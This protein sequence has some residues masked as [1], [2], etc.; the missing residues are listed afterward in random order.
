ML[1]LATACI[2]VLLLSLP[3][4]AQEVGTCEPGLAERVLDAAGARARIHNTGN[5]FSNANLG[6]RGY[7][8]AVPK[9]S[10]NDANVAAHALWVAGLVD[11]DTL[12]AGSPWSP[13]EFWPGPIPESGVPTDCSEFD[14][15]W[16]VRR[17]DLIRY[18]ESGEITE[19]LGSW[20]V[21]L[22]APVIDGD[23]IP[24]NYDLG[25]GDQ[26]ALRGDQTVWWLMNDV[27]NVHQVTRSAPLGIEVRAEASAKASTVQDIH[28]ATFYRYT[29]T[30]RSTSTIDRAFVGFFS[31]MTGGY[32]YQN[33]FVGTDTTLSL[34]YTYDFRPDIYVG[35]SWAIGATVLEGPIILPDGRDNDRD[36]A[37]DEL[38]ERGDLHAT[39]LLYGGGGDPTHDEI[40]S[41]QDIYHYLSGSW[42]DGV[43]LTV[44]G[45]GYNGPDGGLGQS[46]EGSLTRYIFSGEPG[47]FWSEPCFQP[48]CEEP[49]N[50]GRR[51]GVYST[52]PF[53]LEPGESQ[54]VSI[55]IVHAEGDNYLD[56]VRA[57]KDVTRYV[58]TAFDLGLLDPEPVPLPADFL[59]KDLPDALGLG[60][61]FPNPT[62]TSVTLPYRVPA[63]LGGPI[64]IA[65]T[66]VLGREVAVVVDGTPTPGEY[67]AVLDT[68]AFAPGVYTVRMQRALALSE[69]QRFTVVR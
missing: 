44:G 5:L 15:L 56:A 51:H 19:N 30:N 50:D 62:A 35:G 34:W 17:G 2:L 9:E 40:S 68:S 29:L 47:V 27:G 41:A 10:T 11:G 60:T 61:P 1:R 36:G 48:G 16:S 13:Y 67:D 6:W 46:S 4:Q 43:P 23:G 55:A 14:K 3:T 12:G 64:R 45:Y 8:Y 53:R 25:A 37:I 31:E 54:T 38:G 42:R 20:P 52:G 32:E 33:D 7:T 69:V 49:S 26:P 58:R 59:A 28:E 24:D 65:V 39:L 57:L 66:D 63:T 21:H 22:G 18:Y